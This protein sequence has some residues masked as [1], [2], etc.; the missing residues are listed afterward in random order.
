MQFR[1][2]S[3]PW[4]MCTCKVCF[5][6]VC[7][8]GSD[9]SFISIPFSWIPTIPFIQSNCCEVFSIQIN[10]MKRRRFLFLIPIQINCHFTRPKFFDSFLVILSSSGSQQWLSKTFAKKMRE[11]SAEMNNLNQSTDMKLWLKKWKMLS[12]LWKSLKKFK[13]WIEI[14][15]WQIIIILKEQKTKILEIFQDT[16]WQMS[17]KKIASRIERYQ[18]VVWEV[19]SEV[20]FEFV[21]YIHEYINTFFNRSNGNSLLF[22]LNYSNKFIIE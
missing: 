15:L 1:I 22:A 2:Y 10:R 3:S 14:I 6:F 7:S 13:K 19:I 21:N 5:A 4:C 11:S 20:F 8:C 18:N 17:F 16:F 9:F 12:E